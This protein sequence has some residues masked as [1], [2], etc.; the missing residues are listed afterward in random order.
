MQ[1]HLGWDLSRPRPGHYI[2]KA[3]KAWPKKKNAGKKSEKR[4]GVKPPGA[5]PKAKASRK[6]K[7]KALKRARAKAKAKAMLKEDSGKE[8]TKVPK[9][10]GPRFAI[11]VLK[12]R[13]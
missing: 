8:T 12:I 3:H 2:L 13:T 5:M 7:A 4:K 11:W 10:L 9:Q 6:A 1:V